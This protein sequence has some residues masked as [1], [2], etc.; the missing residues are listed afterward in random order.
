M[1]KLIS[2]GKDANPLE[3]LNKIK[4]ILSD[5]GIQVSH[6]FV[7]TSIENCFSSRVFLEGQLKNFI[8][9][10]GKGTTKEFCLA[11]GYAELMERIQNSMFMY[12][13]HY[14]D[15]DTTVE[16]ENM[17]KSLKYNTWEELLEKDDSYLNNLVN[18]CVKSMSSTPMWLRKQTAIEQLKVTFS[19]LEDKIPTVPFYHVNKKE[20]E[21]IPETIAKFF[22]MSNGMSAGNTIEEALVQAYAELFER[23]S[24]RSIILN[25][26]TPPRL[27]EYVIERYPYVKGVIKEIES[28]GKYKVIVCDC[29]LGNRYPVVCGIIIDVKNHNYGIRFGAHP[30]M[31]I[32]LERVFT[33][34]LQGKNLEEFTKYSTTI[35]SYLQE[36]NYKNVFNNMKIGAGYYPASIFGSKPTY[37]FTE[38]NWDAEG[39]N[40][41][42]AYKMS[43]IIQED[44]YDIY[45]KDSSFL[46]FPTVFVIVPGLSELCPCS[47]L[48]LKELK[49][50][51][52][53]MVNLLHIDQMDDNKA[54]Q[55]IRYAKSIR[56]SVLEN[57]INSMYSFPLT[58][59]MHGGNDEIDFLISVCYYYLNNLS[60]AYHYMH[61]CKSQMM[62]TDED[63]VYVSL[64]EKLFLGMMKGYD[65]EILRDYLKSVSD[66][67][68]F[69][70]IMKDFSEP[71]AVL[72]KLYP[73]IDDFTE[74][75]TESNSYQALCGFYKRVFKRQETNDVSM[76]HLHIIFE[77]YN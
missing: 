33:E 2:R 34:S 61:V 60:E 70:K 67:D 76:K 15:K 73:H 32:A 24:Q 40:K 22:V 25:K 38:W 51:F 11:S 57:T 3:T 28:S 5:I 54:L 39:E 43:K 69:N 20:Y 37:E 64:V 65:S 1:D 72:S 59:K 16:I 71:K 62:E 31:G 75:E 23:M 36:D 6:S 35:F 13:L 30:N 9:T 7:E 47:L 42:L 49:L 58:N 56:N 48:Y 19:Q 21:W 45:V 8:G 12:G 10:N 77:D 68:T 46:D 53:V 18:Q 27:P 4:T 52:N 29:S 14:L 66:E 63:Y 55:I 26:I 44:G 50:K 74:S 41:V 17:I